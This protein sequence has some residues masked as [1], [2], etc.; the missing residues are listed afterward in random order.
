[1]PAIPPHLERILNLAR[2]APSGDNT[3]PWRFEILGN[4][5]VLIHGFDTR[6]HVVYDLDGHASQLAVGALLETITIAA[7]TEGRATSIQRRP[8]TPDT[9]LL[10]DVQFQPKTGTLP[11]V[12][13]S[14]IETRVVQ[15]RPMSTRAL[16]LAQKQALA[17]ELP[18]FG[19]KEAF[20]RGG[21]IATDELARR[22]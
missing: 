6:D 11:D 7:S 8:N 20:V 1:M 13:A 2:W 10:F 22:L 17:D 18:G 15:R 3:Q 21:P 9:H 14:C 5:H 16:S 12:L 19:I 4:E